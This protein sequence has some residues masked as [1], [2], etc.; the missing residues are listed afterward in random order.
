MF[1]IRGSSFL[2]KKLEP[3]IEFF[4]EKLKPRKD[5]CVPTY[6]IKKP[7]FLKKLG[8]SPRICIRGLQFF[9]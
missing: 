4:E 3:R 5:F 9:L 7:S 2:L 1:S 6:T 8:F